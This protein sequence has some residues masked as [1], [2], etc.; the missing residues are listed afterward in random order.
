MS[1]LGGVVMWLFCVMVCFVLSSYLLSSNKLSCEEFFKNLYHHV[2]LLDV[3]L[4]Y[5]NSSF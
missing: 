5:E 4:V 3:T 2:S 1:F